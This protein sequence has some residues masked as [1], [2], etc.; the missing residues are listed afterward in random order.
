MASVGC[1]SLVGTMELGTLGLCSS[2]AVVEEGGG[3]WAG[4]GAGGTGLEGLGPV[5]G[6]VAEVGMTRPGGGGCEEGPGTVPVDVGG[7]F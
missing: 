7:F 6:V 3:G 5:T 1:D 2:V 4:S